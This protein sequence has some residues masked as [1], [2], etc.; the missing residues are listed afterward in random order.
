M[1]TR[2]QIRTNLAGA[3]AAVR[4]NVQAELVRGGSAILN[5]AKKD[6]PV[7]KGRLRASGR[8]SIED[9]KVDIVFGGTSGVDYA[10]WQE[11]G[12]SRMAAQP[13]LVPAFIAEKK[14]LVKRLKAALNGAPA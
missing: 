9:L 13:Y 1:S 11:I 5:T 4:R 3:Q 12:T 2:V 8:L 14:E 7:D 10:L 6:A